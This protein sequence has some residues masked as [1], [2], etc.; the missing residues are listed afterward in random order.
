LPPLGQGSGAIEFEVLP[1]E[2]VTFLI[3]MVVNRSVD[4]DEFL[5]CGGTSKFRHRVFS[6]PEGLM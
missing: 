2:E 6:S 3:E 1:I 4:R 5:K